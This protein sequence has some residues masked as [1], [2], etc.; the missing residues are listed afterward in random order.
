MHLVWVKL[1]VMVHGKL[2]QKSSA[3]GWQNCVQESGPGSM[4]V[5]KEKSNIQMVDS[6]RM[7]L[8]LVWLRALQRG[9]LLIQDDTLFWSLNCNVQFYKDTSW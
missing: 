7:H 9:N 1:T 5:V 2:L 4:L 6:H 8:F 3:D